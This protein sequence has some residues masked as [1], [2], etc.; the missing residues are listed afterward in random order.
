M[1]IFKLIFILIVFFKTETVL[2]ENNLF[3]VNNIKIEKK[4]KI[5][6]SDLTN[7]AIK[8]G[9]TQLISRILLE[10]DSRNLLNLDFDS[11]KQLV[12]YYQISNTVD[13]KK[14]EDLMA[15]GNYILRS[16]WAHFLPGKEKKTRG[17]M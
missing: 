13:K 4:D 14:E 10:E 2:S 16:F 9:F 11:I 5:S 7:Q 12:S 17:I 1:K 6:N 8:K 3:N 15:Q